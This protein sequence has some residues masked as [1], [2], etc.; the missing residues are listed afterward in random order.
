ML[1]WHS[2]LHA[3]ADTCPYPNSILFQPELDSCLHAVGAKLLNQI[4]GRQCDVRCNRLIGYFFSVSLPTYP[5]T[6][7]HRVIST[8]VPP[9]YFLKAPGQAAPC[10]Q[11]TY[12]TSTVPSV[13]CTACPS[14][15][16]TERE[17]SPSADACSGTVCCWGVIY[18]PCPAGSLLL[19]NATCVVATNRDIDSSPVCFAACVLRSIAQV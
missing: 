8:G 16:T 13:L 2:I 15:T 17:G 10:G 4:H 7:K 1:L 19:G 3:S 6:H 9:G 18:W 5:H 14:G 12:K 11:G